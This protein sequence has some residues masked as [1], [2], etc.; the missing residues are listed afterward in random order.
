MSAGQDVFARIAVEREAQQA[1]LLVEP[2]PVE[3]PARNLPAGFDPGAVFR[4]M[5]KLDTPEKLKREL[6]R[7]R[8]RHEKFLRKLSPPLRAKRTRLA[9]GTFDWRLETD[10]DLKDF[11]NTLAG[12]GAWETVHVPH[13]GGPLGRARAVYRA[14]FKMTPALRARG[15]LFACFKAVDYKA[16]VFVNGALLGSHEGFFA[17]FEFDFTRVAREGDNTLVVVVENDAI[18]MGN[19]SWGEDGHLY[20]GDKIYAATGLGY[21]EPEVGWH[22]CPPGM[23]ICQDVFV[24]AR[25]PVH[26]HDIFV[27]PLVEE[28]RAEAWIEVTN[29]DRLRRPIDLELSVF[30]RNFRRTV[31]RG[32]KVAPAEPAGPNVNYY[33]V[34]L[35]IPKARRWECE[36]PW[37]YQLQ[38]KLLDKTGRVLDTA[39]RQFGM[40]S[41]RM[42]DAGEPK[43]R[44]LL[45]GRE[46]RLRG[47]NTMGHMQ[48]SVLKRDWDQLRDDI[49]LAKICHMNFFRLTQ[50]PVQSEI[51]D[52]CDR[53]GMMTQTDLPLFGVLRRNQFAEGVRQA[54]EMERLVRAHPCNIT[55]SYIN[56]PFPDK[57][58]RHLT[59]PELE[60]FFRAADEAVRLANPDRVIKAV[61]G[62]YDPPGP[63]LPDNHCYN[64]WYNGHGLDLGKL[65]KGYWQR[66]KPGWLYGCGEFGAEGLDPVAVMRK[67]YPAEWLP[68]TAEEEKTWSPSRITKAQ[69]GRFHYMW[70]DTQRRLADWV[71][72]SQAHQAWTTRLMTEAFRRDSRMNSIAIHLFIDAFPSGWMKTIMDVD[73]EPKPSYF[74]YRDALTPLAANI[75]T[76]RYAFFSGD[77]MRFELWVCNDTLAVPAGAALRYQLELGGKALIARKTRARIE[78][79]RAAFQGFLTL[80]APR[81]AARTKAT[82]RLAVVQGTKAL[83]ETSV[84]VDLFPTPTPVAVRRAYVLGSRRGKAARL[85]ADAGLARAFSGSIKDGDVV[86]IDDLKKYGR[87]K[88]EVDAR[89]KQGALGVFVELPAGAAGLGGS[90]VT[91]EPC[92]M[93]ARHFVSRAT[94]H[95]LAS[96]FEPADFRF[97]HD[98]AEGYVTPLLETTFRAPSWT[99]ILTS[100]NGDWRGDWSPSLAAAEKTLG[101]GTLRIC[102]VLLA[103]R[104]ETNPAAGIFARRLLTPPPG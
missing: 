36:T 48:Q 85:A 19:T 56:E 28:D 58:H 30:G 54:G 97:W 27:R 82:L 14:T 25:S 39:E 91:I 43:G 66:I 1:R 103:G 71:A 68:Q 99:P 9:L 74:V 16:H 64:G 72:A 102:Q 55:V 24:E 81:V 23:G 84:Q 33:R 34:E 6:A 5:T 18:C 49:L 61:D 67:Y 40:R 88:A 37:L 96:G 76:D 98:P 57:A 90:P 3:L 41:F 45:N 80:R 78:K 51:Y 13:Y 101:R 60:R 7:Q 63:G 62:D 20:E 92:G 4:P 46:I 100:G 32:R 50:R 59:R 38:V 29:A 42:D 47:A 65:H 22:H 8:K 87:R 10:D 53:L 2:Q 44:F 17:A 15:A 77:E 11:A 52:Y 26:V 12:D 89:V 69:T 93:G 21:D 35:E 73:R 104:T 79:G 70:F 86:L 94:G 75:R 31:L 83:H 95:P